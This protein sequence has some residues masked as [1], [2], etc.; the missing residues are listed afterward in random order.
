[1]KQKHQFTCTDI[2]LCSFIT[3]KYYT[4]HFWQNHYYVHIRSCSGIWNNIICPYT[5]ALTQNC[6]TKQSI[7]DFSILVYHLDQFFVGYNTAK[8][9]ATVEMYCIP[10]T[11]HFCMVCCYISM[12]A[13][14]VIFKPSAPKK[15]TCICFLPRERGGLFP[16]PALVIS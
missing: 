7:Q 10:Q 6:K 13:F 9:P 8:I 16:A 11:L 1:M 5:S 3:T 4:E 12:L 14:H 2:T 15:I